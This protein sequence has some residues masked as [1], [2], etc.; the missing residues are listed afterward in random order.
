MYKKIF[1]RDFMKKIFSMV[2]IVALLVSVI[3]GCGSKEASNE[4]QQPSS[5][6]ASQPA[7]TAKEPS[8]DPAKEDNGPLVLGFAQVG[9]ESGWRTAET[10]SIQETCKND[11]DVEL[12]FSDAQQKQ[13]NQIKAIRNF[14]AQKV[15]V[16]AIAPVVESGWETVFSEAKEAG[17]PIIL[18]DRGADVDESLYTSFIGS[19]FI[20]EGK[21]AAKFMIDHFGKDAEV[22][23]VELQGTVG[24]SA[25]TDRKTGF[26]EG[27][28]E[29]SGFKI[30]K[31]QT[32]DFTRAK[33]KEVMEAFLKS[34]GENIDALYSHN[35]DMALGALQAI[36]EYGLNP[37]EDIVIVGVDGV[38]GAFE[39]IA[40][41]KYNCTVECN[42]S[43]GPQLVEA[44]KD[45]KAGKEIPRWIKSNEDVYFGQKAIDALPNRTY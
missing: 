2:L 6:D 22:N 32:G 12:I 15:D 26:E 17:I 39:A 41:G 23:I 8:Q 45:L 28:K 11:P 33:G 29:A 40:E 44:A 9:A 27:L 5:T 35:D 37:G 25:A 36:E 10:I 42:P 4:P 16:I 30:T 24:A 20:E 38:K 14:I 34:D 43:L 31:S 19:D 13:E 1:R 3:S 7:D 18:V 21:N